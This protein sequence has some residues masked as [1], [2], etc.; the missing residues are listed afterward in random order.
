MK[1]GSLAERTL[2]FI[3]SALTGGVATLVDL[4]VLTAL[5]ELAH[6]RPTVANVPAL[7]A[8]AVTQFIGCRTVVF[9]AAG[10]AVGPQVRG[11][12]VVE[13]VTLALN[14]LAFHALVTWTP[15]PYPLA[16]PL[17]TFLI[18]IGF[19]YPMWKRVFRVREAAQTA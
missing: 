19:S 1:D 8:G 12:V 18:Y 9:G 13:A 4:G 17:G 14:A 11:F 16:R 6:L 3:R 7:V 15:I 2:R 5:I 10:E